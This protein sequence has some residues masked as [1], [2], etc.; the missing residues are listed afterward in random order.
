M[1]PDE[2]LE[3]VLYYLIEKTNK[4]ARRYSQDAFVKAGYDI[5]VDQWLVLKKIWDSEQINQA[6]LAAALFKDTASITRILQILVR[7]KLVKKDFKESDRRHF[8]LSLT[9]KG[10]QFFKQVQGFVKSMRTQGVND[11]SDSEKDAIKKLLLK[12]IKN[13][14]G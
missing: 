2:K 1:P 9:A 3:D 4:V 6:E 14:E 8:L 11:F 12:M 10:E 5:T 13:L 7:K